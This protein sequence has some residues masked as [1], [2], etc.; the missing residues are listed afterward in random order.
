MTMFASL[1]SA[2]SQKFPAREGGYNEI[3]GKFDAL[4]LQASARPAPQP[5]FL[6]VLGLDSTVPENAEAAGKL[7]A[8]TPDILKGVVTVLTRMRNDDRAGVLNQAKID[9]YKGDY[10][11]K[12]DQVLT[13]EKALQ[14]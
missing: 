3:I 8:P 5:L 12:I 4:R 6:K 11:I 1:T 2:N 9:L 7:K 13:Y 14:R 10:E